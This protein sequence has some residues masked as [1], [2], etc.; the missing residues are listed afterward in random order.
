[1]IKEIIILFGYIIPL[2][3]NFI[4]FFHNNYGLEY[5]KSLVIFICDNIFTLSI[6]LYNTYYNIIININSQNTIF[7][8]IIKNKRDICINKYHEIYSHYIDNLNQFKQIILNNYDKTKYEKFD[9]ACNIYKNYTYKYLIFITLLLLSLII[10]PIIIFVS[11]IKDIEKTLWISTL[12]YIIEILLFLFPLCINYVNKINDILFNI[13]FNLL[14]QNIFVNFNCKYMAKY[15]ND[16]VIKLNNEN[17]INNDNNIK[18]LND[19]LNKCCYYII[20]IKNIIHLIF[21]LN[22]ILILTYG[23]D[24][25]YLS[26]YALIKTI[27]YIYVLHM[28]IA[29]YDVKIFNIQLLLIVLQLQNLNINFNKFHIIV[30]KEKNYRN[31]RNEIYILCNNLFNSPLIHWVRTNN[32]PLYNSFFYGKIMGIHVKTHIFNDLLYEIIDTYRHY[33][34][35]FI[36]SSLVINNELWDE[37]I[38]SNNLIQIYIKEPL[39]EYDSDNLLDIPP[40]N[41]NDIN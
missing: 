36:I 27:M 24:N 37:V 5:N 40:P 26:I 28:E 38:D 16:Y 10:I 34:F 12:A 9:N 8:K 25:I 14:S 6:I 4:L 17:F 32:F 29:L 15:Y 11:F 22:M 3:I 33:G 41:Y 23:Y 35:N 1:M 21:I 18:Y 7:K 31:Y 39:P 2:V 19:Y 30:D 13:K 20:N